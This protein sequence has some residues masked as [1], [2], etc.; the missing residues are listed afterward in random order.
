V[1]IVNEAFV[2]RNFGAEPPLGQRLC[3]GCEWFELP[4]QLSIIGVV[5]DTKQRSLEDPSPPTVFVPQSQTPTALGSNLRQS[6]FV[7]RTAVE[8]M[9]LAAAVRRELL[10]LDPALPIRSLRP[11]NQL[12]DGS[13]APQRFNFSL[14]G[15]FAG[16]GMLLAAVGIYGV[17]A[18]SV[19][20]RTHEIG[21]R[22]ALGARTG[23]V[24]KLIVRQGMVLVLVGVALGLIASVAL[25]RIMKSLLFGVTATDPLTLMTVAVLLTLVALMA[26]YL[27]A[28]RAT[29]VDPLV[30]LRYE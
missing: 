29:K 5:N 6:S 1:A 9:Q 11:M 15:L 3:L 12:L 18:Y 14:L 17:M 2:R 21:V 4:T 23:D 24:L 26:C 27:P 10:Q 22:M 20:Q 30:A 19:S 8:P 28:R 7:L 13:I 16:I 25:T